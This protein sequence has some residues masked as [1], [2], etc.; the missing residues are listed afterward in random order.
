[1]AQA[2]KRKKYG[3]GD[4]VYVRGW[5]VGRVTDNK[6]LDLDAFTPQRT[7]PALND[8]IAAL[9]A[10]YPGIQPQT[11]QKLPPFMAQAA[12]QPSN[13][14]ILILPESTPDKTK[15]FSAKPNDSRLLDPFTQ[16]DI[17][18]AV[19]QAHTPQEPRFE[20][21]G[22]LKQHVVKL[23]NSTDLADIGRVYAYVAGQ[24]G[25][26]MRGFLMQAV[27]ILTSQKGYIDFTQ[28][29]QKFGPQ[30][31]IRA[32][33]RL[34]LPK[35]ERPIT[36]LIGQEP[37]PVIAESEPVAETPTPTEV[38]PETEIPAYVPRTMEERQHET[39]NSYFNDLAEHAD[40]NTFNELSLLIAVFNHEKA[41][42]L[43]F[44]QRYII[45]QEL[46]GDKEN[47]DEVINNIRSLGQSKRARSLSSANYGKAVRAA[48]TEMAKIIESGKFNLDVHEQSAD[49]DNAFERLGERVFER[50]PSI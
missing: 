5:G 15:S 29:G 12:A 25:N 20:N 18:R 9:K 7:L 43:N 3:P 35:I 48:F 49:H 38:K 19:E 44:F 6:P 1:M 32:A 37:K 8:P 17:D 45:L 50:A 39:L 11:E 28:K 14:Q 26:A 34:G 33:D 41:N 22:E 30:E 24:N 31:I 40:D 47:R 46:Y 16:E 2:P 27:K 13:I 36:Y 10:Q 23:I 42:S 21:I 4:Y